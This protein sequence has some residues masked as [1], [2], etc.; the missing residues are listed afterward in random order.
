MRRLILAL[1]V[2]GTLAL[3][4]LASPA[5]AQTTYNPPGYGYGNPAGTGYTSYNPPGYGYGNPVGTGVSS[6][7]AYV[8][9]PGYGYGNPVGT[10]VGAV[11]SGYGGAYG[12]GM[13][14]GMYGAGM[15]GGY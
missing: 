7:T 2:V 12:A 6:T 4:G 11:T 10:G 8:N 9:P 14:G 1:S 15:Y 13:Y 3:G 5:A